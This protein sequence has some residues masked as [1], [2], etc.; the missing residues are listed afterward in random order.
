MNGIEERL[1]IINFESIDKNLFDFFLSK[2]KI[3]VII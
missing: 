2:T 3:I 1:I